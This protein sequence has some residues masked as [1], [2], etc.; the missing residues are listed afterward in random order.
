VLVGWCWQR[1]S[2]GHLAWFLRWVAV[3]LVFFT[4]FFLWYL[5][6]YQVIKEFLNFFDMIRVI[7]AGWAVILLSGLAWDFIKKRK[8]Y[9]KDKPQ[10][11]NGNVS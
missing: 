1:L 7:L 8:A 6:R 5:V 11:S 3:V 2:E 9:R 10:Q 4:V